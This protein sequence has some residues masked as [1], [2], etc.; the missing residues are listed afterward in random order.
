MIKGERIILLH[1]ERADLPRT[2]KWLN[3]PEVG[4][5]LGKTYPF[6]L[7]ATNQWY[8]KY[9][10]TN[11]AIV[12][13]ITVKGVHIGVVK[14]DDFVYPERIARLSF[15]IG[16][17]KFLRRGYAREAVSAM[18][19][20]GFGQLNLYKIY[21]RVFKNNPNSIK[22]CRSVGFKRERVLRKEKYLNGA[23]VDVIYMGILKSALNKQR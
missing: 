22:L 5:P 6:N 10:S 2:L 9:V 18:L 12:F 8:D 21:A 14:L 15:Y 11:K 1:L 16:D 7:S 20:Y 19:K 23:Y 4:I 3:N 13:K 17:D